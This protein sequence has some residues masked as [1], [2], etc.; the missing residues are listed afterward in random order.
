[1]GRQVEGLHVTIPTTTASS[2]AMMTTA[3]QLR[4]SSA[5][6][7]AHP[8]TASTWPGRRAYRAAVGKTGS[9]GFL[10]VALMTPANEAYQASTAVRMPR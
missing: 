10:N 9:T 5:G 3:P 7:P 2:A 8:P 4:R 1:V 6:G